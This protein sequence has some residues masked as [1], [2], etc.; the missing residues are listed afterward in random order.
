M[1]GELTEEGGQGQICQDIGRTV[2]TTVFIGGQW[3]PIKTSKWKR[4]V[5]R[6]PV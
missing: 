2:K 6:F 1:R 5:A 4:D 3:K